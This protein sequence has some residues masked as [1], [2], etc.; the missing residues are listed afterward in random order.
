MAHPGL[1]KK[2]EGGLI[3]PVSGKTLKKR[4]HEIIEVAHPEDKSSRLFDLLILTLIALNVVA[5]VVETVEGIYE[6]APDAFLIFDIVSVIVFSIEYLLRVWS[7]TSSP[8]FPHPALGEIAFHD[9]TAGDYRFAGG[10][11]LFCF[12]PLFRS[13]GLALAEAF[14]VASFGKTGPLLVSPENHGTR[15]FPK[16]RGGFGDSFIALHTCRHRLFTDVFRRNTHP[17]GCL[18]QYSSNHVVECCHGHYRR[19]W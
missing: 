7:C 4:I 9:D 6:Q 13:A 15:D 10:F 3:N 8:K 5:L 19:L 1:L 2:T 18:S 14:P 12:H 16:K 17:A 11:A